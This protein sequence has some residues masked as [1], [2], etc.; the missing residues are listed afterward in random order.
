MHFKPKSR[1]HM[2]QIWWWNFNPRSFSTHQT[3]ILRVIPITRI[4]SFIPISSIHIVT[5]FIAFDVLI[6]PHR[7]SIYYANNANNNTLL[8]HRLR[9]HPCNQHI[10]TQFIVVDVCIP[11]HRS[12]LL[13]LQP[14]WS[15]LP[16]SSHSIQPAINTTIQQ[17]QYNSNTI[18]TTI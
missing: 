11:S 17:H 3:L 5:P 7:S 16:I 12:L 2:L 13:F 6:P 10:I 14:H 1:H 4:Q 9:S 18:I 15:S 8:T